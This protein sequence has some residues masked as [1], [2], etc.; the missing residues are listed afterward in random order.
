MNYPEVSLYKLRL[1]SKG[2][3]SLIATRQDETEHFYNVSLDIIGNY[4]SLEEA[5]EAL[6]IHQETDNNVIAYKIIGPEHGHGNSTFVESETDSIPDEVFE[7]DDYDES[8]EFQLV[9]DSNRKIISSYFYDTNNPGGK[10]LEN[11]FAFN[12]GDKVWMAGSCY[13]E[14][15]ELNILLPAIIKSISHKKQPLNIE[16]DVAIVSPLITVKCNWGEYP[17]S[18]DCEIPRIDLLPHNILR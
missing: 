2:D 17:E 14:D 1:I 8:P 12:V 4:Y 9:F 3:E 13:I 6:K 15:N 10:R 11:E 18:D 7:T 16:S 5:E